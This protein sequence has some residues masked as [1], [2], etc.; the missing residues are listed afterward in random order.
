MYLRSVAKK[1]NTKPIGL[2][3]FFRLG[4]GAAGRNPSIRI[5]TVHGQVESIGAVEEVAQGSIASSR[6]LGAAVGSRIP[7]AEMRSEVTRAPTC[8]GLV[9]AGMTK[10]L[11]YPWVRGDQGPGRG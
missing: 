10:Y 3:L 1:K 7:G 9:L 6:C 11:R 4:F 8:E 2:V 5:E